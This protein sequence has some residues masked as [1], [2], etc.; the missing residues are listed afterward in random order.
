[1]KPSTD[2]K[3][4]GGN[5]PVMTPDAPEEFYCPLT[6]EISK[7]V[8]FLVNLGPVVAPLLWMTGSN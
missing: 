5:P 6:K 2:E 1:M 4:S 8:S 7:F 3:V